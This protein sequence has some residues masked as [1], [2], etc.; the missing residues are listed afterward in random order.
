MS[1]KFLTSQYNVYIWRHLCCTS[2]WCLLAQVPTRTTGRS[3][4]SDPQCTSIWLNN[5]PASSGTMQ[6]ATSAGEHRLHT[7]QFICQYCIT[8]TGVRMFA[9]HI[10]WELY[11]QK[12]PVQYRFCKCGCKQLEPL[13]DF[14]WLLDY[15]LLHRQLWKSVS[16]SKLAPCGHQSTL[17]DTYF[18]SVVCIASV[19]LH[20]IVGI[21]PLNHPL[22]SQLMYLTTIPANWN[23]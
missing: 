17:H 6:H 9:S 5:L 23:V 12:M 4:Q 16:F 15:I 1:R 19:E 8:H 10:F 13:P 22:A 18:W 7:R 11:K 3:K 21:W 20:L 2:Q 14:T